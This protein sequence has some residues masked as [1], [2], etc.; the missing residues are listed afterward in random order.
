MQLVTIIFVVTQNLSQRFCGEANMIRK[1]IGGWY[2]IQR[3]CKSC[4]ARVRFV[5]IM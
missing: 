2:L 3:W 4:R 1:F 5:V